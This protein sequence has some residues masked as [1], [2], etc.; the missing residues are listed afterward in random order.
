MDMGRYDDA[1]ARYEACLEICMR[2]RD[3]HRTVICWLNISVCAFEQSRWEQ[4]R[5]QLALVFGDDVKASPRLMGAGHFNRA[6][7][8]ELTG[9]PVPA[10][11]DYAASLAI[12]QACEQHALQ[13]DSRAGLVRMAQQRGDRETMTRELAAI[14]THLAESGS[15]GIEHPGRLHL[16]LVDAYGMLRD[17]HQ[18]RIALERGLAMLE[19]R[20]NL[21]GDEEAK[22][23]FR[24]EIP[25]HRALLER[26]QSLQQ[27]PAPT[28]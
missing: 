14:E 23:V 13:I 20:A 7:L 19:Q 21:L 24:F 9:D 15:E 2:R 26:A 22:R 11:E 4:C 10:E 16:T 17:P 8:A 1:I 3:M 25:C 28:P 6:V 5:E 18:Q 12:R 27:Q